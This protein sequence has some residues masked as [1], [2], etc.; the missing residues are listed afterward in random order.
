MP[1]SDAGLHGFRYA[2]SEIHPLM[3]WLCIWGTE[4]YFLIFAPRCYA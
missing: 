2:F 4:S 3:M 1:S